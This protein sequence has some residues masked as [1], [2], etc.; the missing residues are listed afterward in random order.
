MKQIH[1][2][3]AGDLIRDR[4]GSVFRILEDARPSVAYHL[5][6]RVGGK[7]QPMHGPVA[8]AEALAEYVSGEPTPYLSAGSPWFFQADIKTAIFYEVIQ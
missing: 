7:L 1:Q 4:F 2:F 5:W 3:R 6:Q 8:V